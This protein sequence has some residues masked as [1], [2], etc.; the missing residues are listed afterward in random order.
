MKKIETIEQYNDAHSV[1]TWLSIKPEYGGCRKGTPEQRK[2][3]REEVYQAILDFEKEKGDEQE[4][5][6]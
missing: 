3:W 6:R 2:R 5:I 4:T 1:L